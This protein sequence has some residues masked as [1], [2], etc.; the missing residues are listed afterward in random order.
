MKPKFALLVLVTVAATLAAFQ[1]ANR[2]Q[3]PAPLENAPD[4]AGP[5][6]PSNIR[7]A[8]AAPA[9]L[10]TRATH[11]TR[12]LARLPSL[13]ERLVETNFQAVPEEFKPSREVLN[14]YLEANRRASGSLLAAF[15]LSGDTNL[16]REAATRFPDDPRVQLA[17]LTRNLLPEQRR[18]WLEAFKQSSP[19]N[20]LPDYL[21]A[22][23]HLKNGQAE[24][25]FA[26]LQTA[27]AKP[28]V[29]DFFLPAL[30]DMEEAHLADGLSAVDAKLLAL[31]ELPLPHL[32][33]L[34][35]LGVELGTAQRRFQEIGDTASA[36]QTA[37]HAL[38]LG[39]SLQSRQPVPLITELVGIAIERG[40]LTQ[41]DAATAQAVLGGSVEQRLADL[42]ASREV[43]RAVG[44]T[45]SPFSSKSNWTETDTLVYLDR[46]KL[47]GEKAALQWLQQRQQG[48]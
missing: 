42:E 3:G 7:A 8:S 28:G 41:L 30:Q 26:D 9:F 43:I 6:R 46:M 15:N 33:M 19:E 47:F 1:L 22:L 32:Q 21:S 11:S 16:L 34:R 13:R 37:R 31:I 10:R 45:D 4:A 38:E 25:A 14:W 27:A 40:M 44:K 12:L 2:F 5:S 24:L 39:A 17:V 36:A 35:N 18:E 23:D 29:D 20:R 48:R